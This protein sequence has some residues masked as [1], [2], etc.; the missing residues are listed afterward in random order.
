MIARQTYLV[1]N[2]LNQYSFAASAIEFAVEDLF[3]RPEIKLAFGNRDDDFPA[4]YL[5][6][7]MGVSVV[8]AGPIVLIGACRSVR[9][10]VFQPY[11][12]IVMQ[13]RL[14][15]VDE[16]RSSDMHGVY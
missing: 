8:F 11:V 15:V 3:P 6:L 10:K 9:S 14:I 4:H 1:S 5:P 13:P 12:V 7:E 16:H 2:Y